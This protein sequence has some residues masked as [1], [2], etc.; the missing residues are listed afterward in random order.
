MPGEWRR[1]GLILILVALACPAPA[2]GDDDFLIGVSNIVTREARKQLKGK[3]IPFTAGT[4][5]GDL[6]AVDPEQSVFVQVK[7]LELSNDTARVKLGAAGRFEVDAKV[8]QDVSVCAVF[9]ARLA[10]VAEAQFTQEGD[11]F[12]VAPLV[13][14]LEITLSVLEV[15]RS[16]LKGGEELLSN[17]AMAAFKKNKEQV[18]AEINKRLGKRPF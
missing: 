18:I 12:Y 3:R 14:D 1:I 17:L 16:E 11:K 15:S 2:T 5:K 4:I 8:D 9:D 10:I 6:T 7:Q 13:K